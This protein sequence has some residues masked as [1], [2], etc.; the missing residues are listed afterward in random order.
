MCVHSTP[1]PVTSL[2]PLH[3][4]TWPGNSIEAEGQDRADIQLPGKQLQLLQDAA[5]AAKGEPVC[6]RLISD[7]AYT[8][9]SHSLALQIVVIK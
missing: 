6:G 3:L 2:S 4:F 1:F 8:H 7:T 5:S 9:V